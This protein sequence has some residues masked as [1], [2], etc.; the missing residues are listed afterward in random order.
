MP[1]GR[2]RAVSLNETP[3]G[4]ARRLILIVPYK[5]QVAEQDRCSFTF[6]K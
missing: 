6:V 1:L 4:L 3:R 2:M 5:C